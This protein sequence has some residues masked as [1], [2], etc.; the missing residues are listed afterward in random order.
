MTVQVQSSPRRLELALAAAAL[1]AG[2]P[3]EQ[4][5]NRKHISD[6]HISY[7][8][9]FIRTERITFGTYGQTVPVP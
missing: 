7:F 1:D 9:Q 8:S 2:R 5:P 6:K 3:L 4:H